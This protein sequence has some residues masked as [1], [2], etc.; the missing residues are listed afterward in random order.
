MST[1]PAHTARLDF[2]VLPEQKNL[3]EMAAAIFG[4]SLTEYSVTRLVQQAREDIREHEKT[5]L[6]DRDRDIFMSIIAS[7]DEPNEAMKRA[8]K[9]Y[10]TRRA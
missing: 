4:S 1:V 3:I 5:I 2:R 10:K 8:A 6:S 9:R 7:D